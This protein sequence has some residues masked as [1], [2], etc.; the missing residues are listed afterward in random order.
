MK[1]KIFLLLFALPFFG[2]GAWMA[3][4]I[5]SSFADY[6]QMKSWQPVEANLQSAGY[7]THSGDDSNT[8][9]AYASYS[10][11]VQ[12]RTYHN[13]RV[14]IS[15]GADNI[16]DY[17]TNTGNR[18]SAAMRN[19]GLVT[20]YVNPEDP[21]DSIIDRSLRWGLLGFK[22]I[23]MLVFGG[24][25]LGLILWTLF[26]AKSSPAQE[27]EFGSK[28]WL[29]ND[30][31]QSAVISSGSK[32]G[33]Y[34]AWIFATLW[35]LISAPL[36]FLIYTEVLE[37]QNYLALVGLLFPLVGTG[38][39]IWALRSTLE[40]RRFGSAPVTLDPFPGSIGGH[41]GGTIDVNVPYDATVQYSVT[42][43]SLHSYVSGS[44]KN[45]SRREKAGWQ[46]SQVA[47]AEHGAKGARLTFRFDVPDG[48][49]ESD[50]SRDGERYNLWRMNLHAEMPGPDIDRDYEI[51][52]YATGEHSQNLPEYSIAQAKSS[53]QKVD[54]VAV[55]KLVKL[56]Y[57]TSGRSMLFP[58]GRNLLAGFIG[59]LF[60]A[61]FGGVGV[62]LFTREHSLFIG[63]GFSL[64][65]GLILLA[66]LYAFLNSLEV[67]QDGGMLR[68]T[69]RIL[70]LPV[71][72]GELQK[73][74]FAHFRKNSSSQTQSGKKHTM[75]YSVYAVDRQANEIIVGE[76]LNGVSEANA[77]IRLVA[78]EFGLAWKE[79]KARPRAKPDNENLLAPGS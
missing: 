79:E 34:G 7:E 47:H 27:Q 71:K 35:S 68:T 60:A 49:N 1:G 58:A 32:S 53:Q 10:Y 37:K 42:L 76:G 45:R 14:G 16:G 11:V 17:Q 69:R 29:A 48:L 24:V 20:V 39:F 59:S 66:S 40:W 21:Q 50:A 75:H 22:S 77:L 19:G 51:P 28:P 52:V 18:L 43:T 62:F 78:S 54:D 46:D 6:V 2:V 44:G 3:W 36:P 33:M 23:F 8:Y 56:G 57:G 9:E 72:R 74:N 13:D 63:A 64:V 61:V 12:G 31:W 38:L 41:V 30:K 67:Y 15:G 26:G 25:G 4:S 5:G 70:G 73:S 65:G 55:R